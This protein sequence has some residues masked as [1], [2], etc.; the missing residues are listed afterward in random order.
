MMGFVNSAARLLT[1]YL[2]RNLTI[3]DRASYIG[4]AWVPWNARLWLEFGYL[5]LAT[6]ATPYK[7]YEW[8]ITNDTSAYM[9][10]LANSMQPIS[11][12][13]WKYFS[14]ILYTINSTYYYPTSKQ[15]LYESSAITM[16][17]LFSLSNS[18]QFCRQTNCNKSESGLIEE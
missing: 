1:D 9:V 15:R 3:D 18:K 11:S 4:A 16:K 14:R 17:T 2:N 7:N 12:N 5:Q 13:W 6:S 10:K 8:M